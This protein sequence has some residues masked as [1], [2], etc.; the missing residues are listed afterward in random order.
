[1]KVTNVF[2]KGNLYGFLMAIMSLCLAA[3]GD[4]D[5]DEGPV[6]YDPS[7]PVTISHF[8]PTEGGALDDLIIYGEN[9]GTD[10][11]AVNVTIGD[12]KAV[13]VSV[14]GDK[15][16]CFVPSSAFTGEIVV[17]VTGADGTEHRTTAATKFNY[18]RKKVVSTLCGKT[19]DTGDQGTRY[20]SFAECTG[21]TELGSMVYDPL[22]PNLLYIAY[23]ESD[24]GI[25]VL[26]FATRKYYQLM[27]H[28]SFG[29]R[30]LRA[31][32]F[33]KD[34]QYMLVAVDRDDR[35]FNTPSIFL[36]KR[37]ANGSFANST[38]QELVF[39]KQC[40]TVAVHP[41]GEIYFNSY[42]QGQVFRFELENYLASRDNNSSDHPKWDGKLVSASASDKST[43]FE[44][45][46]QI[47]D[48]GNEFRICIHPSGKYA[49]LVVVNKHYILR[50][51]YDEKTHRFT[52]PYT[53]VGAESTPGWVDA[54]STAARIHRP[55][56]GVFVKNPEYVEQGRDDVYDFYFTDCLNF[57]VRYLTP[58]GV[59][60]TYAGRGKA[61]NGNIWGTEDGDL[62]ETARFRDVSGIAYD[63]KDDAFYILDQFN[64]RIRRIGMETGG[65]NDNKSTT[66]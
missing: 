25:E 36:L 44:E 48:S 57:C 19:V 42:N 54:V 39:F 50:T 16:Y 53:V 29:T 45:V 61:T 51:D 40:N 66:E 34:G 60:R 55:Y 56:N 15:I 62:R 33:S 11:N 58:D 38:P 8:F 43:G 35:D 30:R 1:M 5:L 28:N 49:Y 31:I 17:T 64:A 46:F 26:D 9:F 13:V 63:E 47:K 24:R 52:V 59:V 6:A 65:D 41:N 21:F 23:D 20:G 4:K 27:S 3:C 12:K 10:K 22:Q 18:L 7:K 32:D 37:G 2:V 14:A